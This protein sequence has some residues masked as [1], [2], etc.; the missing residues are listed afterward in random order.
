MRFFV[1]M[2]ALIGA[3]AVLAGAFGAH[4]LK[5]N[6]L[7]WD[8]LSLWQTAVHYHL[9]HAPALLAACL[10]ADAHASARA[11]RWLARACACWGLGIGLFSG[12]LYW[13]AVGGPHWLGPV[14]PLGGLFLIAGWLC[15]IGAAP[16]RPAAAPSA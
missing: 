6:L 13:L 14:T 3:S 7:A 9:I 2:T 16:T 5:G 8:T 4:A 1:S 15:V 11:R 10:Y 12:S